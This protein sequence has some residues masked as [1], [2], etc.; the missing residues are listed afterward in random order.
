MR[1]HTAGRQLT[2]WDVEPPADR[3]ARRRPAGARR[4]PGVPES[5]RAAAVREKRDHPCFSHLRLE[6]EMFPYS[7][8]KVTAQVKDGALRLRLSEAFCI[9]DP[10][11]VRAAVRIMLRKLRRRPTLPA[12]HAAFNR[13]SEFP[14]ARALLPAR[15]ARVRPRP[16]ARGAV[17]DLRVLFDRL[18]ARYFAGALARPQLGWSAQFK[19]RLGC[20]YPD[21]DLI[22]LNQRL[23]R[24]DA[25]PLLVEYILFHEMLHQAHGFRVVGGRRQYHTPQFRQ[26]EK[27]FEGYTQAQRL[28]ERFSRGRPTHAF[29]R[30]R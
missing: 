2:L 10:A 20:F 17:Y 18:N 30:L 24:P 1:K 8:V 7:D 25:P 11:T 4:P 16:Q 3:P 9:A 28:C 6:L 21:H 27:R 29:R 5:V 13:F 26:E 14:A 23:D 15:K 22:L 12:D 19:N